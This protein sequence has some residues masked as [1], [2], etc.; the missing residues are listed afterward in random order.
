MNKFSVLAFVSSIL[1]AGCTLN[2]TNVTPG[3]SNEG[4]GGTTTTS[5]TS[6]STSSTITSTTT[7]TT[8]TSTSST[9]TDTSSGGAGGEGGAGGSE[10]SCT[11]EVTQGIH[12][13]GASAQSPDVMQ[14][15]FIITMSASDCGDVQLHR[16]AFILADVEDDITSYIEP[17]DGPTGWLWSGEMR[18]I[19][20]ASIVGPVTP[21]LMP[22]S[23]GV[24]EH[25]GIK[26]VFDPSPEL[27]IEAGTTLEFRLILTL[28]SHSLTGRNFRIWVSDL[29]PQYDGVSY[30]W[31]EFGNT[32]SFTVA[33]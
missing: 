30:S 13:E 16:V 33:P 6:T 31:T 27:W 32:L 1:V 18:D 8:T 25:L 15:E 9:T 23:D 10:P 22:F 2:I 12:A 29:N 24:S 17:T 4:G 20:F 7:S 21:I 11:R 19:S 26:F 5:S 3:A 14:T 28:T